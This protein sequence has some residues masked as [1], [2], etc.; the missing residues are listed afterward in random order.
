MIALRM[1]LPSGGDTIVFTLW[2]PIS[3]RE[4]RVAVW[5]TT[6]KLEL[7]CARRARDRR[8]V[9]MR[10]LKGGPVDGDPSVAAHCGLS[11]DRLSAS[12]LSLPRDSRWRWQL[13]RR[14]LVESI[15]LELVLTWFSGCSFSSICRELLVDRRCLTRLARVPLLS[16]REGQWRPEFCSGRSCCRLS[17][18]KGFQP[19]QRRSPS[20]TTDAQGRSSIRCCPTPFVTRW[21][22]C[23]PRLKKATAAERS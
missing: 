1:G 13:E 15:T 3:S 19:R 20:D 16:C 22:G 5:S 7:V 12:T 17:S 9:A 21:A 23:R 14:P 18:H 4:M 6:D 2:P 11:S 10:R 8:T